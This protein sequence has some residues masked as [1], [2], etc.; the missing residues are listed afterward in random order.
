MKLYFVDLQLQK[1]KL[2]YMNIETNRVYTELYI[3][4]YLQCVIYNVYVCTY[5]HVSS[6]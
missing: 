4:A 3:T 2:L 6:S 5:I 1:T